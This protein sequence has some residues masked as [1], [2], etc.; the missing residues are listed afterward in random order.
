MTGTVLVTSRSFSSGDVDVAAELTGAGLTVVRGPASHD[1][2]ELR[3]PLA[4][5]VAWIAGTGRVG[6]EHFAAAPRLRVLARY[7]VGVDAVDLAA[8]AAGGVVVTNTPGANTE[9]VADL[10]VALLLDVLRGVPAGDRRVREGDWSVLRGRELGPLTVGVIGFGRIGRAFARRLTG[11]GSRVLVSDPLVP[12]DVVR[13]AGAEPESPAGLAARCDAVS[14]HTPGGTTLIDAEWLAAAAPG[15][16]IVNTARADLV[17]EPA[18]AA[19]LRAGRLGGYGADT[20]A[21]E[22]AGDGRSPLLDPALADRVVITPHVGAQTVEAVDRMGSLAVADVL[23][24]LAGR[25]P[26][27]PVLQEART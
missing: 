10:A 7:G 18:V 11:F 2:A 3:G 21:H 5:A 1:L 20:L 25:E 27:H 16:V 19:A 23:A 13:A 14:L 12:A 26:A 15:L 6:A 24:V 4:E 9:A 22:Y 17:D 8:A